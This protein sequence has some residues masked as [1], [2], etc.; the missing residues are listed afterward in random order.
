MKLLIEGSKNIEIGLKVEIK[1]FDD[2]VP[3]FVF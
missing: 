1:F 2:F 3:H